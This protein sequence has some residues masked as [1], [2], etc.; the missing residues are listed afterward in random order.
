MDEPVVASSRRIAIVRNAASGSAPDKAALEQALAAAGIAANVLDTPARSRFDGWIDEV[1]DRHDV[2]A[3][4]GGDGTVSA[5]AAGVARADKTLAVLPTGTLNHFARDLGIPIDL[6]PALEVLRAGVVS[7]IDLGVV[8]DRLFLNNVSLGSYPRMLDERSA[9]EHKGHSRRVA[10]IVAVARTWWRLRSVTA[11]LIV[12]DRRMTRR[13]PFI[14]IGNGSYALSGFALAR[15]P[16][17]SDHQLSLYVA[18]RAGR[19]GALS[20]PMRALLGT[21]D[22]YEQF[23]SMRARE[24]T[25]ALR[26]RR[27]LAGIDGE[28]CELDSPMRFSVKPGALKV[29]VPRP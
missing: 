12:D 10:G 20:M 28:M 22:R 27:V 15:R 29:L 11:S 13:T 23:E 21:L 18:P 17:I 1:A 4:A 7:A 9:L 25:I 6:A 5:V 16:N 14:V 26:R 3:A 24:I 2:I 19:L 8:N